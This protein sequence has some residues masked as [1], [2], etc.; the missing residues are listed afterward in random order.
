MLVKLT[1][2]TTYDDSRF[3]ME[4]MEEEYELLKS[5]S[6]CSVKTAEKT[7]KNMTLTVEPW[8]EESEEEEDGK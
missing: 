7:G 8:Y 6:E 1:I 2:R 4:I 3:P 5:V